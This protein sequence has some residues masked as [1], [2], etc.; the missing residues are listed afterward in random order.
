MANVS[1]LCPEYLVQYY[2][3]GQYSHSLATN[4]MWC[5]WNWILPPFP[6]SF[7]PAGWGREGGIEAVNSFCLQPINEAGRLRRRNREASPPPPPPAISSLAPVQT[8][9]SQSLDFSWLPSGG[10]APPPL[11]PNSALVRF[12]NSYSAV[13]NHPRIVLQVPSSLHLALPLSAGMSG[14]MQTWSPSRDKR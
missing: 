2:G 4:A 1:P 14:N 12:S 6:L 5:W 10:G 8:P 11:F 7:S 3:Q 9:L 13:L